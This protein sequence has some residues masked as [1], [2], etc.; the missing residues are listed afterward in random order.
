MVRRTR[1]FTALLTMSWLAL[2]CFSAHNL[3]SP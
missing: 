1:G 2:Q 3:R